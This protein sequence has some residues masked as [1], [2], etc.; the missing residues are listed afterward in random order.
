MPKFKT[1]SIS[2][3]FNKI[4]QEYLTDIENQT[5]NI[6]NNFYRIEK[7]IPPHITIGIFKVEDNKEI[8]F[9]N[10]IKNF[11]KDFNPFVIKIEKIEKIKNKILILKPEYSKNLNI[12]NLNLYNYLNK[13]FP[14]GCNNIYTPENF[15]PH[16]TLATGLTNT[17]IE[18][19]II[20]INEILNNNI[21]N[22]IIQIQKISIAEHNPYKIIL[23]K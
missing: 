14:P 17:Q 4:S 21:G 5:A 20:K 13:D 12:L 1:Y 23:E 10:K 3:F 9:L 19:S 2:L 11:I 6:T 18:K 8:D 15:F 22:K 7:N 16:I